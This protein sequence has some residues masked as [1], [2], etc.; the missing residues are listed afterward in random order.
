MNWPK[1][2][3]LKL[4]ACLLL[5]LLLVVTQSPA[6]TTNKNKEK[7]KYLLYVPEKYASQST[8]YPLVIYLHG[9]SHRGQDLNKLKRYGLPQV[10]EKGQTFEFIIASPQCP[11]GKSW[12][13][14][15]WL[16]PLLDELKTNYRIDTQRIYLTGISMGG[17]GTWQTAVEYPDTFAAIVPLCGGCDDSTQICRIKKLPVWTFHG[18]A[19]NVI[20]ISETEQLVKRLAECGN[21]V[22]FTRLEQDGHGIQYLY[23]NKSIYEWLLKQHR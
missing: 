2:R 21:Q 1:L 16:E 19:D 10:V 17:Y 7:Y 3:L 14:D 4:A 8:D 12:S 20:P 5:G 18:A 9:S 22:T 15:N 23:E 6:Q 13:T 11:D